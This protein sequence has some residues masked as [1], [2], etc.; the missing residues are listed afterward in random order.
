MKKPAAPSDS[1]VNS[2]SLQ[3][4]TPLEAIV[5]AYGTTPDW[6]KILESREQKVRSTP[7]VKFVRAY[8]EILREGKLWKPRGT[9]SIGAKFR[10][11]ERSTP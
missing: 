10:S 11:Q 4:N 8:R 6:A 9:N 7:G 1:K 3:G 2:S 5:G